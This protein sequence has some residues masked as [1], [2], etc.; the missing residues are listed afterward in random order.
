M[1][2]EYTKRGP[3]E[4]SIPFNYGAR[5]DPEANL[6]LTIKATIEVPTNVALQY[7][8][9]FTRVPDSNAGAND[10]AGFMDAPEIYA[11]KK[12]SNPTIPPIAIPLKPPSPLVQTTT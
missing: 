12:I 2:L 3:H 8:Q 7:S 1:N 11:R 6:P 4:M 9:R 10:L 5:T